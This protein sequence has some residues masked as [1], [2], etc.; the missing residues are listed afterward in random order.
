MADETIVTEIIV[1][2]RAATAGVQA[3]DAAMRTAQ[4][5]F[6]TTI[7]R[8][9]KTQAALQAAGNAGQDAD[10]KLAG[11]SRSLQSA[12]KSADAYLGRL[13]PLIFASNALSKE[14][15][16]VQTAMRGVDVQYMQG[17]IGSGAAAERIALLKGRYSELTG[18]MGE[19]KA[20]VITSTQAM[21]LMNTEWE[22]ASRA[23][24]TAT[25]GMS[26]YV[27][28]AADVAAANR[29]M[30]TSQ[31]A[32]N[33]VS[34]TGQYGVAREQSQPISNPLYGAPLAARQSDLDAYGA[35]LDALR[36]KFDPVFKISKDYEAVLEEIATAEKV[37]AINANQRAAAEATAT[38]AFSDQI[39][40]ANGLTTAHGN[41]NKN[42][43]EGTASSGQMR[44]ATQQLTVQMTQLISGIA[45]GQPIFTALIQQGHQIF[46][47][48]VSTGTGFGAFRQI[49]ALATST[50]GLFVVGATAVVGTIGL[51]GLAAETNARRMEALRDTLSLTTNDFADLSKTADQAAKVLA[52]TT[53]ITTAD[54]RL[55]SATVAGTPGFAGSA[56]QI[57]T[58]VKAF[59]DLSIAQGKATL[60]S[61]QMGEALRDPVAFLEKLEPTLKTVDSSLV[62]HARLMVAAGD[63]AG[64]FAVALTAIRSASVNVQNDLTPLQKAMEHLRDAMTSGGQAAG[65]FLSSI[66]SAFD[67]IAARIINGVA[68]IVDALTAAGHWIDHYFPNLPG[69]QANQVPAGMVPTTSYGG[70][71]QVPTGGSAS[72]V[73]A[74]VTDMLRSQ[75]TVPLNN[76]AIAAL[77]TNFGAESGFNPNIWNPAGTSYGI[78][79]AD[80][81]GVLPGLQAATGQAQPGLNQQ[82]Q[83]LLTLIG[84]NGPY[85]QLGKALETLPDTLEGAQ[86]GT[87][88]F[89]TDFENPKNAQLVAQQRATQTAAFY[90]Q[91]LK[92]SPTGTG[93]GFNPEGGPT[94]GYDTGLTNTSKSVTDIANALSTGTPDQ[95]AKALAASLIDLSKAMVLNPDNKA[96]QEA[97]QQLTLDLYNAVPAADAQVRAI[98]LNIA[99]QNRMTVAWGEGSKAAAEQEIQN[100]ALDDALKIAAPTTTQYIQAVA[101]LTSE[102]TK[103]ATATERVAV[104]QANSVTKDQTDLIQAQTATIGM[105]NDARQLLL[106]HMKNEQDVARQFP[107]ISDADREARVRNLDVLAQQTQAYQNMQN[108]VN[109]L[110]QTFGQAFDT[111]GNSIAQAFINGQGQA[112]NWKN[113]MTSVAEQVLQSFIKLAVL[114]PLLNALLPSSTTLPTL[115]NAIAGLSGGGAG[116]S[117]VLGGGSL[118]GTLGSGASVLSGG[119]SLLTSLGYQGLGSQLGLTG[120]GGFLSGIGGSVTNFLGTP[121]FGTAAETAATN[122]ALAGLGPGVFGPATAGEVGVAGTTIGSALGGIGGGFALGSLAGSELQK[123]RGTTGP[124]PLIG[125]GLGALGGAA[126][127][128]FAFPGIGT[129]AGGLIGGL[130]GGSGGSLIGPK[131]ATP[132]TNTEIDL[133]NGRASV[134]STISQGSDPTAERQ[135]AVDSVNAL[136]A[137]LDATDL[138]LTSLGGLNRIGTPTNVAGG[139]DASVDAGFGGFSFSASSDPVLNKYLAGK[140]YP[141][142]NTLETDIGTYQTLVNNTIP[143]LLAQGKTTG[144]VTDA[145][146]QLN[147]AFQPAIATAQQYGVATD[148]LTAAQA[149]GIKKVNDAAAQTV[150]DYDEQLKLRTMVAQGADAQTTEL[151]NFDAGVQTQVDQL[152]TMMVGLYGDIYTSTTGYAD[153]M[154]QLESTL[155]AERL[156]I[157]KKYADAIVAANAQVLSMDQQ[158]QIRLMTAQGADPQTTELFSFDI[159]AQQQRQAFSD[160]LVGFYGTAYKSTADYGNQ[161]ALLEQTL[162][163][164]RLAIQKKYTDAITAQSDA[165]AQTASASIASLLTYSVGLQSSTSSPLSPV[166]QLTLARNQ[167]NAVAGAAGAGDANSISQLQTYAQTFLNASR[168]V[169]GSGT[170]YVSDFQRVL[171]AISAVASVPSDTLTASVLQTET[172]TQTA[173]LVDTL[174][175]LKAAVDMITTQLRQNAATPARIAA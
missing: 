43:E 162:G 160:Q 132:F 70:A 7:D 80:K 152:K 15:S 55:G 56:Q 149:A 119:N 138:K 100:K 51:M 167:F 153:Q 23:V 124:S 29:L 34:S 11:T 5:S 6:D 157:Q 92:G 28:R 155:G 133:L 64:A 118:I 93:Q 141:D 27:A 154:A 74:Q 121:I 151:A 17:A 168:V 18:A 134:G 45:S 39:D 81:T 111:I 143:A 107:L 89:T 79:Q 150:G 120:S 60:D 67:S 46:D 13:D 58:V 65:G 110:A 66:G 31:Q 164:E 25:D 33:Q 9:L 106:D 48:A 78:Y 24:Q 114:N 130:L 14:M 170:S 54:A 171:D 163:A 41:L 37:G 69:S 165:A 102:Y 50:M 49:F 76:A 10:N 125:A 147:A 127:G 4:R 91:L 77:L 20:G 94:S 44:F 68:N 98:E 104:A 135:A 123:F 42:V 84:P 57:E 32:Y 72:D 108:S 173:E 113:V 109:A 36:A 21:D 169:Y 175:Q 144:S 85:W 146:N 73:L 103:Q 159:S 83:Y 75:T 95:K 126:L 19:L 96:W 38:K 22:R 52:A 136:N 63:T 112:V 90:N 59:N 166:D 140:S 26:D 3:L 158:L 101:L 53:N 145:I 30:M 87:K 82:I 174:N 122:S 128:T 40:Q 99:A 1:D 62:E 8:A 2:A 105:N 131:K 47:V 129:L 115:G 97:Q 117:G 61:Q 172:R 156:A 88:A 142:L 161:M 86:A 139:K 148:D 12:A 116:A 35:S 71:N 16:G 137:Y